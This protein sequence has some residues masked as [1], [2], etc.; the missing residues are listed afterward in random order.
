MLAGIAPVAATFLV[1][2][3]LLVTDQDWFARPVAV[4]G[5]LTVPL[6]GGIFP[7]LLVLAARRRGEYVP[8]TVIGVIGH[9]ATVAVV[10]A[11]FL[12]GIALHGLVIWTDPLERAAALVVAGLT[13]A[14]L[15]WILR[16]PAFRRTA[17]IEIRDAQGGASVDPG[18][19]VTVG[20]RP[21]AAHV[22]LEHRDGRTDL[23][24]AT[25]A[26]ALDG[27]RRATFTLDDHGARAVTVWVHRV[28]LEG[29][30]IGIPADVE[31]HD[32]TDAPPRPIRS[33]G[34]LGLDLG[35][36]PARIAITFAPRSGLGGSGE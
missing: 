31:L 3:Y 7:M 32:G 35:R 6:L 9:P 30:S 8:G 12:A 33:Q 2:E 26:L 13:A 14:L 15:I 18:F 11:I 23:R 19:T 29:E 34:T 4:I 5:V 28:T 20:G 36:G 17:A 10:C 27:L 21:L 1:L 16:G 25:G 22:E 24:A